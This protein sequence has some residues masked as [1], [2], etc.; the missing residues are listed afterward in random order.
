MPFKLLLNFC[1]LKYT[2]LTAAEYISADERISKIYPPFLAQQVK[3]RL[4]AVSM[5]R[6]F[7]CATWPGIV[8]ILNTGSFKKFFFRLIACMYG[9]EKKHGRCEHKSWRK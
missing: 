6:G 5:K 2:F 1:N 9:F 3:N 4:A 8:K 7:K